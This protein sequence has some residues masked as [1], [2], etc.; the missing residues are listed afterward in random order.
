MRDATGSQVCLA[1][2]IGARE[3]ALAV[4][5]TTAMLV[6]PVTLSDSSPT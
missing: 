6:H 1:P 4:L 5:G 2:A 3:A